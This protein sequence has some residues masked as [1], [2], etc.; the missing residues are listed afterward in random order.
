MIEYIDIKMIATRVCGFAVV[1]EWVSHA[2]MT[3][4]SKM[5]VRCY[6]TVVFLS[7]ARLDMI[8]HSIPWPSAQEIVGSSTDGKGVHGAEWDGGGTDGNVETC[9]NGGRTLMNGSSPFVGAAEQW[10]STEK[11]EFILLERTT[12]W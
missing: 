5:A 6:N 11:K 12:W 8:R 1:C 4:R 7:S 2:L 3:L 10:L 9:E